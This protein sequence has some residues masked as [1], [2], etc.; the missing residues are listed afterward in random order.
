HTGPGGVAGGGSP[1]PPRPRVTPEMAA[2][3]CGECGKSF[4]QR[5]ALA[6]HRKTH[7]GE[8]PHR[9]G[10]CGKSFSRGS[11]LTQHRRIHTG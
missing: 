7:T 8:R 11:N 6:K 9:C 10:E 3:C 5:S 4:A 2:H 1:G